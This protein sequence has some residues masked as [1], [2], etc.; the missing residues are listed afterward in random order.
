[1]FIFNK[2]K[3]EK[4]HFDRLDSKYPMTHSFIARLDAI[5]VKTVQRR[6]IFNP[7]D[8]D[9]KMNRTHSTEI[10]K[11]HSFFLISW[12]YTSCRNYSEL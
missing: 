3:V 4:N 11:N 10:K 1:M 7:L 8:I 2:N 5:T 12:N 6:T 9:D